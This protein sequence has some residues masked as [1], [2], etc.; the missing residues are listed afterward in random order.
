MSQVGLEIPISEKKIEK[1][2]KK[3][4]YLAV[5]Q[6]YDSI[7]LVTTDFCAINLFEGE[8]NETPRDIFIYDPFHEVP[9]RKTL[10]EIKY[11][12]T[13]VQDC[14]DLMSQ[15]FLKINFVVADVPQAPAKALTGH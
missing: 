12:L 13:F 9:Y 11:P 7:W 15:P 10:N 4:L 3:G 6:N 8:A 14:C 2:K 1:K 5:P